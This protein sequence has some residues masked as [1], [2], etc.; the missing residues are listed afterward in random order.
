MI[1]ISMLGASYGTTLRPISSANRQAAHEV[2]MSCRRVQIPEAAQ[3][4]GRFPRLSKCPFTGRRSALR[5]TRT[6]GRRSIFARTASE[7]LPALSGDH[8]SRRA[9]PGSC[10]DHSDYVGSRVQRTQSITA[11]AF[12]YF[13]VGTGAFV[14]AGLLNEI[15]ND[16]RTP[17]AGAGQLM[18]AYSLALAIGAPLHPSHHPL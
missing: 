1:P 6:G 7:L 15:A 8:V 2:E 12:G 3:C 4:A 17:V 11:L 14:V 9:L 10:A 5:R 13:V 16:L 18:S